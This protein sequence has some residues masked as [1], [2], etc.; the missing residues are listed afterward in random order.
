M[1]RRHFPVLFTLFFLILCLHKPSKH[2]CSSYNKRQVKDNAYDFDTERNDNR[3]NELLNKLENL[4]ESDDENQQSDKEIQSGRPAFKRPPGS[5]NLQYIPTTTD[6]A[7]SRLSPSQQ[8][9]ANELKK[10]P[11]KHVTE[12]TSNSWT[13]FFI[14]CVLA[15]CILLIHILIETKFHFLPE[16]VAIVFL[17]AII[18]LLFKL[19]SHYKVADW[20]VRKLIF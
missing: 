19:L 13:V 20:S 10:E 16:S 18:G 9:V 11:A 1:T 14:L 6:A 2:E 15:C 12:N 8:Q 7:S 4:L 17:G 5:D 3:E